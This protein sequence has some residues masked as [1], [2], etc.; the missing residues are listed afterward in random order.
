MASVAVVDIATGKLTTLVDGA[1]RSRVV[2]RW[3]PNGQQIAYS[4]ACRPTARRKHRI[5]V[6]SSE[7][8]ASK[9]I[10]TAPSGVQQLAWSPDSKT[11]G[12]ATAD[13]PEKKT[14]YQ[15][16]NDS[17]EVQMNDNFLTTATLPPTHVWMVASAG[18]DET[19]DVRHVDAS[20]LAAARRAV[21]DH[22]V[23]AGW[24]SIVFARNGGGGATA[25][26][27]VCSQ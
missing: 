2:E 8:G 22:H 27:Q 19:P 9:Q 6:V 3:A 5:F 4:P 18:R 13:E 25:A 12:F 21:V 16:W 1:R 23:H 15:R 20:R 14:G 10:T 7:G 11:I 26:E 24:S 17:F